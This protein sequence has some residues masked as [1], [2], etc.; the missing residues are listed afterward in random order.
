MKEQSVSRT[1]SMSREIDKRDL[2]NLDFYDHEIWIMQ[3]K[4]N[5]LDANREMEA[6]KKVQ[7]LKHQL[8][9]QKHNLDEFR[10]HFDM[11]EMLLTDKSDLR[12]K[13]SKNRDE[14]NDIKNDENFFLHLQSFENTF[15]DIRQEV[16]E[17]IDQR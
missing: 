11:E 13:K 5:S 14:T 9:D 12:H 16:L 6:K 10:K 3:E 4:L 7:H 1:K 17:F 8:D 2:V 15:K